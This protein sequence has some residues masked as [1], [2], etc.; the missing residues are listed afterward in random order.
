MGTRVLRVNLK[1]L[2]GLLRWPFPTGTHVRIRDHALPDDCR[3]VRVVRVEDPYVHVLL[4]SS[5]WQGDHPVP[6]LEHPTFHYESPAGKLI[7]PS[8]DDHAITGRGN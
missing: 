4:M 5:R 1:A 3:F 6:L 2:V 7:L 8:E